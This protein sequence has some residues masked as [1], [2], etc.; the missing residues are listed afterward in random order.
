MALTQTH[1]IRSIELVCRDPDALARFYA[2]ALGFLPLAAAPRS[3]EQKRLILRLGEQTIALARPANQG[4]PYPADLPPWRLAF[5]HFA[6]VVSDMRAALAG[7][8]AQSGWRPIS[9][10]GPQ[11]L[12]RSSGGVTA[13]KFRDPEGH[14]LEFLAFPSDLVPDR[15]R[16][17]RQSHVFLGVDHSAISV[18]DTKISLEFYNRL[19][20][21]ETGR[22]LNHGD[23]QERLDGIE[24]AFVEVTS[25]SSAQR[26]TPHL[27]FLCYRGAYER[28]PEPTAA[29]DIA[30]TRLVLSAGADS[31]RLQ[32]RLIRDPDGHFLRIADGS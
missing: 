10:G 23:E 19:G 2:S 26:P 11:V 1:G 25:L 5:Q 16:G 17:A 22:S 13:F 15:W 8:A 28:T 24:P 14:P 29:N 12:P 31:A 30:A 27:E 32:D 7:L 6:I 18:T 20:F 3:D 21:D 4:R 9:V